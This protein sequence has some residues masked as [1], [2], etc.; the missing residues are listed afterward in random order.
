MFLCDDYEGTRTMVRTRRFM[1]PVPNNYTDGSCLGRGG[2]I[3]SRLYR[4]EKL[5]FYRGQTMQCRDRKRRV[6]EKAV[7]N[8]YKRVTEEM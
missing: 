3:V 2:D 8:H 4:Q 6:R 7:T 1:C 5:C